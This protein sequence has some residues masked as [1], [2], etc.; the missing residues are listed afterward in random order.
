MVNVYAGGDVDWSLAMWGW[1][2]GGSWF[3]EEEGRR[4]TGVVEFCYVISGYEGQRSY[5]RVSMEGLSSSERYLRSV[6]ETYA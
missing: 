4:R 5:L 2:N 6:G 3:E 1:K